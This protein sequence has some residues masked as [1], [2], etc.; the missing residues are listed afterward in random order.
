MEQNPNLFSIDDF[1]EFPEL[2]TYQLFS[3]KIDRYGA[4][5]ETREKFKQSFPDFLSMKLRH[6]KNF[7]QEV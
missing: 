6:Q 4:V 5:E 7:M 1:D 3:K 2:K